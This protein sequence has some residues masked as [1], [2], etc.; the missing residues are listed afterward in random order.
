MRTLVL[1]GN[2]YIGLNLV[3]ELAL[4]GHDVTV[5]NSHEV[6]LPDGV[7]RLHGD[8]RVPGVLTELLG[9][10]RDAFDVVFD[11]TAYEPE[12]LTPLVELFRGRVR[13]FV[14]TSSVA[15]YRRS[16]IQPVLESFRVHDV[17]DPH[18]AKA[19]GL[20]KITCERYLA[21]FFE[22]D[23][24]PAT[25][26][27]VGHTIG[28]RSPLVT[29]E[30]M[31]FARLEQGRP[32]LVPGDGFPFLHFIHVADVARLM[33]SLIGNEACAGQIY[34]VLG[35]EIASIDGCIKLMADAVGVEADIVHVP[36]DLTRTLRAPLLHW[37]EAVLGGTIYSID[38]ALADLDWQ[39][40]FGL[41]D[42]YRDS[43]A[44]F[45]S[46]GRDRYDYDFSLDDEVLASL[47]SR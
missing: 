40:Q 15:V 19:Y 9:P 22:T 42:G 31:L 26:L 28:P 14:F 34:N 32:I 46:E 38:K 3:H 16:Y 27:R 37:N 30:P 2:R 20:G 11:N 43:Y 21:G 24:F 4:Q 13:Q 41:A 7:R 36:L 18:P 5:A 45:A 17:V 10:Y 23:G 6:P 1:G 25:S 33:V 8:R 12:D 35:R 44:W 29:R 39:P 47:A